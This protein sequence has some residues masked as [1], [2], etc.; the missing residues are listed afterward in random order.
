MPVKF[1]RNYLIFGMIVFLISLFPVYK[2]CIPNIRHGV[3]LNFLLFFILVLIS[4]MIVYRSIK[5]NVLNI[6]NYILISIIVKM[7]FASIYFGL[8]FKYFR[9][10]R[11]EL[12]FFVISFFM[13]YL[14]FSIFEVLFLVRYLNKNQGKANLSENK[15]GDFS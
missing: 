15:D 10:S 14:I 8:T 1:F 13:Y 2:F 5:K 9:N 11:I 7:L 6:F 12:Y 4:T 3:L